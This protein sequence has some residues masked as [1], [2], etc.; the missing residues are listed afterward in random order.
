MEEIRVQL[1][2]LICVF[3]NKNIKGL[4]IQVHP[5]EEKMLG[6]VGWV[7]IDEVELIMPFRL[8]RS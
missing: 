7:G 1:D 8:L 4:Q 5:S 2:S 3:K 6:Q